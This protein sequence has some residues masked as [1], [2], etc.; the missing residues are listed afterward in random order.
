MALAGGSQLTANI[1]STRTSYLDS[2]TISQNTQTNTLSLGWLTALGD[3]SAIVSVSASAGGEV[4]VG[5][6]DD[7]NREFYGPRV[8]FQKTLSPQ[9][10]AYISTGLTSSKYAGVNPYYAV[11]RDETLADLTVGLT[12]S[13]GKGLSLRPQVS[14]IKNT[15]NAEVYAY[16]KT[17]ASVHVRMDF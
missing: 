10:G 3:G 6:R 7:G 15:S 2:T 5:G 16:D 1:S 14:M 8:F 17:D 9:W 12:W 13:L 11:K 4:A